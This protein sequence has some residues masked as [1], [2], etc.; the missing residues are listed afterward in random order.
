MK[1]LLLTLVTLVYGTEW[2]RKLVVTAAFG[3]VLS[4]LS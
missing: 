1:K 2:T 3:T 4:Q